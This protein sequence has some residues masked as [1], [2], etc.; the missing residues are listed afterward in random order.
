MVFLV[1]ELDIYQENRYI[2]NIIFSLL[3]P[4]AYMIVVQVGVAYMRA[5]HFWAVARFITGLVNDLDAVDRLPD[6][7]W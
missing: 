4:S 7:Q 5:G 1:H 2:Y 6:A 3:F